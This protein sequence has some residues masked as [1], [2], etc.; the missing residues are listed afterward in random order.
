MSLAVRGSTSA[1]GT[2]AVTVS[3]P[4][5]VLVG[6]ILIAAILF[7]GGSG[8]SLAAPAGWGQLSRVDNGT[9]LG[10][11]VYC[12]YAVSAEPSSYTWNL[13]GG[14]AVAGGVTGYYSNAGQ[15]QRSVQAVSASTP[16]GTNHAVGALVAPGGAGDSVA[17]VLAYGVLA[18]TTW[19]PPSGLTERMDVP[20]AGILTLGTSDVFG[21]G[22][23]SYGGYTAVS[24]AAAV[25][26]VV[27]LE[28]MEGGIKQPAGFGG[29]VYLYDELK[30]LNGQ[31]FEPD[32]ILFAY[33]MHGSKR[34]RA[35]PQWDF[36][37]NIQI[38][39]TGTGTAKTTFRIPPGEFAFAPG[40]TL[41][42]RSTQQEAAWLE[43]GGRITGA[44]GENAGIGGATLV[45]GA[46]TTLRG[47]Q[48]VFGN[49]IRIPSGSLNVFSKAGGGLVNEWIDNT[50]EV[51]GACNLGSATLG[52]MTHCEGNRIR[53][54]T[55]GSVVANFVSTV[56][57][58]N[59]IAAAA[60]S[61][62]SQT[63]AS[64]NTAGL[65]L[66]GAPTTADLSLTGGGLID[67]DM[68]GLRFSRGAKQFN[69]A[70][71]NGRLWY[72]LVG[73]L[74]DKVTGAALS[75][76]YVDLLDGLGATLFSVPTDS[77]GR[78]IFGVGDFAQKVKV[79]TAFGTPAVISEHGPFRLRINVTNPNPAYASRDLGLF[80]WPRAA[81]V[82]GADTF[83]Q[84]EDIA[85][86]HP[87]G[88]PESVGPPQPTDDIPF[89]RQADIPRLMG[90]FGQP[91]SV[92]PDVTQGLYEVRSVEL[93]SHEGTAVIAKLPVV[94]IE[95]GSLPLLGI[96]VELGVDG[97]VYKVW[98]IEPVG[99]GATEDVWCS[100]V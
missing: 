25:G 65:T 18:D 54:A 8:V 98:R 31:K 29:T 9:A 16:S 79:A 3:K 10:L 61:T 70:V 62:F 89:F 84:F 71:V 96:G 33:P 45:C 93:L 85:F 19:T 6:D 41:S 43:M 76:I 87:L 86:V 72:G 42:T 64:L 13:T 81:Y 50:I 95:E 14:A 40:K 53:S 21:A 90:V 69:F 32:E 36:D 80:A 46:T 88:P 34:V 78:V 5:G 68:I 100:E 2:G 97:K 49:T 30:S 94:T 83:Y 37:A 1:T 7:A 59:N 82:I 28:I 23:S 39:D 27:H 57:K 12:R 35:L 38:L 91:V 77:Q 47:N 56:S 66:I 17:S 11:A 67:S 22:G 24:A 75:G 51:S 99:D 26:A 73:L 52:N 74:T 20:L 4:S 92:G 58:N 15:F 63:G 44:N 60:P 55:A 48:Q